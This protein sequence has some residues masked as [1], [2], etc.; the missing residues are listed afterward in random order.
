[1]K[2]L[3]LFITHYSYPGIFLALGLG[4]LG[5]PIPDELLMSFVGFLIYRGELGFAAAL[6]VAFAGTCCGITVGYLL[7]RLLGHPLLEKHAGRIRLDPDR[8]HR[9]EELYK[10]YG[11]FALSIGYFIP[12]FRHM[13]AI[14]AGASLMRYG[15]FAFFAYLGAL[16]WALTFI[17][18][19]Y[20]LGEQW[21]RASLYS[22]H[23]LLPVFIAVSVLVVIVLYFRNSGTSR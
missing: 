12:G 17:S 2:S 5:L 6:V 19:G 18:L 4:I 15:R 23:V 8:I 13:A 1:M 20:F 16:V 14:F 7:G 10:R 11:S 21:T 22:H 9:A 3:L